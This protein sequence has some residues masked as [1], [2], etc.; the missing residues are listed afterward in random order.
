MTRRAVQKLVARYVRRLKLD[1]N[2]T[3]H[4]FRVTALTTARERGSAIIDLQ[5]FA[6]Q[7]TQALQEL[8]FH[9]VVEELVKPGLYRE[10]MEGMVQVL[11]HL[12]EAVQASVDLSAYRRA[13]VA[14]ANKET[15]SEGQWLE[16]YSRRPRGSPSDVTKT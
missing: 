13:K 2:V 1:P 10:G 3:V 9:N 4:T 8:L 14:E 5:A 16:R 15:D 7:P 6:G 11:P 12:P